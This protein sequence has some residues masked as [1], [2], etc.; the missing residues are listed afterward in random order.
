MI[1]D[2]STEQAIPFR[3]YPSQGDVLEQIHCQERC[4]IL[5]ARQL[6]LTWLSAAYALWLTLFHAQQSVLVISIK[7]ELAK[8]YMD[9]VKFIFDHLPEDLKPAVYKRTE[10]IL[11]FGREVPDGRGNVKVVGLNS[12]I[13]SVPT[14]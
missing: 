1:Q 13:K 3:L 7:E 10:S 8:E 14:S 12:Q 2:L 6:G 9:R 11:W 4:I 5:K